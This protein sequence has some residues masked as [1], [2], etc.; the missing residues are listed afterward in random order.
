MSKE[1]S[2]KIDKLVELANRGNVEAAKQL[3][4]EANKWSEIIKKLKKEH[5][6]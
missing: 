4:E 2:E 6:K 1:Y 3:L 5:D